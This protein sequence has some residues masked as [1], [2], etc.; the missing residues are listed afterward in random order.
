MEKETLFKKLQ[1]A[2][3]WIPCY[4]DE[5]GGISLELLVS[6]AGAQYLPAFY[7]KNSPLGKFSQENL[8]QMEFRMLRNTFTDMPEEIAGIVIEPF[9]ENIAMDRKGLFA[10]DAAVQGMTVKRNEHRGKVEFWIPDR[11]PKGLYDALRDFFRI[12][13]G[14]NQAW[15]LL[16]R[17]KG[18]AEPHLLIA[19]DF[20]GNRIHLFPKLAEIVKPF[21]QAGQR[22]ELTEKSPMFDD[23]KFEPAC[24]YTRQIK[25]V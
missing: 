9:G 10:Y 13:I 6:A 1:R 20:F 15:V 18:E 19:V 17:E 7:D 23:A 21:M 11:M 12:Q 4:R 8:V 2:R 24:I 22:F 25:N 5:K 16:A 14:V 3:V